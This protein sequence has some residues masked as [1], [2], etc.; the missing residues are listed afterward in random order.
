[1]YCIVTVY[2]CTT[3]TL[4]LAAWHVMQHAQFQWRKFRILDPWYYPRILQAAIKST[5]QLPGQS[6]VQSALPEYTCREIMPPRKAVAYATWCHLI[7]LIRIANWP[8]TS[9][10]LIQS[11][12]LNCLLLF[13]TPCISS[14]TS[15]N[16]YAQHIFLFLILLIEKGLHSRKK[17]PIENR[18]CT[19]CNLNETEDEAHF[20]LRYVLTTLIV[21]RRCFLI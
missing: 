4:V 10:V 7:H 15:K 8:N 17:I 20:M 16:C 11:H 18:L 6:K 19:L 9:Y 14:R 3:T 12:F 13:N 5:V 21:E 1:M 2:P